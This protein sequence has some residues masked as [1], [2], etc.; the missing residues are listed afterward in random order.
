MSDP[1]RIK[2]LTTTA[3]LISTTKFPVDDATYGTRGLTLSALGTALTD[4]GLVSSAAADRVKVYDTV[5]EMSA[6][7]GVQEGTVA[8]T[9]GYYAAMDK[10][11]AWYVYDAGGAQTADGGSVITS[12]SGRWLTLELHGRV[13]VRQWGA[14][15]DGATDDTAIIAA[16]YAYAVTK[17]R[18][19]FFPS[20]TYE[21]SSLT[22]E[23]GS[24]LHGEGGWLYQPHTIFRHKSGAT[25]DM[26]KSGSV[27]YRPPIRNI[28][29][30]GRRE[31]NMRNLRTIA[32]VAS[33]TS[34]SVSAAPPAGIT[35]TAASLC[36]F[37]TPAD[38]GGYRYLGYGQI[39]TIVGN[40]V[41]IYSATDNYQGLNSAVGLLTAGCVVSFPE[42]ITETASFVD[43][44]KAGYC[45]INLTGLGSYI[46]IEQCRFEGWHTCIRRGYAISV[47]ARDCF[48]G[49]FSL[50][51]IVNPAG[52]GSD[53]V[54]H[55]IDVNGVYYTDG[56][57]PAPTVAL[58]SGDSTALFRKGAFGVYLGGNG[59]SI[60]EAKIYHCVNNLCMDFNRNA[61]LGSITLDS[62]VLDGA[63]IRNNSKVAFSKVLVRGSGE[64]NASTYTGF[65]IADSLVSIDNL[66]FPGDLAPQSKSA[67]KTSGSS[68]VTVGNVL[69]ITGAVQFDDPI[70]SV[71]VPLSEAHRN[72]LRDGSKIKSSQ[73]YFGN[74][75][76]AVTSGLV[77][78]RLS[79]VS[80]GVNT[81]SQSGSTVTASASSFSA[82]DVGKLILWG[83][84]I[85]TSYAF[86]TAYT[87][88]TVVTVTPSQT[89]GSG[90]FTIV[91][92]TVIARYAHDSDGFGVK[93]GVDIAGSQNAGTR[94]DWY[95]S[96]NAYDPT[97]SF[98]GAN[99]LYVFDHRDPFGLGTNHGKRVHDVHVFYATSDGSTL[100]QFS[101]SVHALFTRAA[102]ILPQTAVTAS[103]SS[104]TVT[105]SGSLFG[106]TDVGRVVRIDPPNS[107]AGYAAS[108]TAMISSYTSGTSVQI[109]GTG[110]ITAGRLT[111]LDN[112]II[113]KPQ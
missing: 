50:G 43:H 27:F 86:I 99:R 69:D 83:S 41:T 60:D 71:Q 105:T 39:N 94:A 36:F 79:E 76:H 52:A 4:Y 21:I 108:V 13:N 101:A 72:Q 84:G 44:T 67:I 63:V 90:T 61:M 112:E 97:Y 109:D 23:G 11:H 25:D 88:A 29:F 22:L 56:N 32:S 7:T 55:S 98:W 110:S 113:A 80:S 26:I 78:A 47:K 37:Y 18:D 73:Q 62:S 65:S 34:F 66:S 85:G 96:V 104:S 70:N 45:A 42:L 5:A 31:Q 51:A 49:A 10:G 92:P 19:L 12:A 87:S 77:T 1:T 75:R 14:K 93:V 103:L 64:F 40:A 9:R 107:S 46:N 58:Y 54:Y 38:G 30:L 59:S 68:R 82:S 95:S 53:D 100:C 33:R 15:G 57:L 28:H 24:G 111:F 106:S 91:S 48:F 8:L 89:V 81:A 102:A 16:A 6:A 74:W 2:D 35:G 3:D 20:G 17:A